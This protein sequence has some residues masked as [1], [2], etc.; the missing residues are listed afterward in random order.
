MGRFV[1]TTPRMALEPLSDQTM[2]LV[3]QWKNRCT[4]EENSQHK[5][6]SISERRFL[7]CRLVE[8]TPKKSEIELRLVRSDSMG[9]SMGDCMGTFDY[10]RVTY[11]AL[12]YCW[13]LDGQPEKLTAANLRSYERDGIPWQ[14]LPKTLKDAAITTHL[15]GMRYLWIDSLCI[16]Q[17]DGD[18]D[19]RDKE[20]EISQMAMVYLHAT[21]TIMARRGDK[22]AD[23][24]LHDRT[25]PS[26]TSLLP[27]RANDEQHGW[28]T[29]TFLSAVQNEDNT[30]LDTRGWVMQEY[31][32]S[33]RL[34]I[35]GTWSTEWSCR[36]E[37]EINRDGWY[38][39]L[40]GRPGDQD[41]F[42]FY[43]GWERYGSPTGSAA[44]ESIDKSH[45]SDAIM[46]FSA[47]PKCR[48]RKPEVYAANKA[49]EQLIQTY[50]RRKL[51]KNED[52]ILAISG[53]AERFA[54]TISQ[55]KRYIAG[56]W[57]CK[58]PEAL[59]WS[60]ALRFPSAR[61]TIY[62][63]PSWSWVSVNTPTI[64]WGS[65]N[66]ISRVLS[67]DYVLSNPEAPYGAVTSA[68]LR[69]EGPAF[70]IDWRYARHDDELSH[71]NGRNECRWRSDEED[72]NSVDP[73]VDIR[74]DARED[75]K[76]WRN[77]VLLAMEPGEYSIK[78]IVLTYL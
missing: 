6:C 72:E 37:R 26:G 34:I 76:R 30:A 16:M 78:G 64:G 73:H 4:D 75:D 56:L 32:L 61:P 69:I 11:S 27:F 7:P 57:E 28:V 43:A 53:L 36:K 59:L 18:E 20:K 62:Q 21:F 25:P 47:N 5:I 51:S 13:G 9:D 8:L 38:R 63:G 29:V 68:A 65:S 70:S 44:A 10:D 23:G 17:G 46:F 31:V 1:S 42:N 74:L 3:R 12:S 33:R 54:P 22:A 24:F 71:S 49:W 58:M 19:R 40:S 39:D 66:C 55:S 45:L 77:V 41:P 35:F 50:T 2:C 48:H 67:I 15:L 14:S 52:R 60:S